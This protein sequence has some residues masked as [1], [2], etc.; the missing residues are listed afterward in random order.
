MIPISPR[1]VSKDARERGRRSL[2]SRKLTTGV[3]IAENNTAMAS[4]ATTTASFSTKRAPTIAP[5]AISSRHALH[6]A[7]STS[8][9]GRW[10]REGR[11]RCLCSEIVSAMHQIIS[12]RAARHPPCCKKIRGTLR[13]GKPNACGASR[14]RVLALQPRDHGLQVAAQEILVGSGDRARLT[15]FIGVQRLGEDRNP[16]LLRDGLHGARIHIRLHEQVLWALVLQ[17][18]HEVPN[19]RWG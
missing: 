13:P 14:I 11:I 3:S 7:A 9:Y 2:A 5:P 17:L 8:P 12:P 1:T 15:E 6:Q 18:T 19:L 4:G 10:A 16:G